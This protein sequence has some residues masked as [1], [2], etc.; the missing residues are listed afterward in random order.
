MNFPSQLLH[1]SSQSQI[2]LHENNCGKAL[3]SQ[4]PCVH[5]VCLLCL[6]YTW[7][8]RDSEVSPCARVITWLV[9]KLNISTPAGL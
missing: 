8:F 9:Q 6:L 1:D 7:V 3:M 2:D 4:C 5:F